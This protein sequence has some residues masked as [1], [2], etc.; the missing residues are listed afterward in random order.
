[1]H[2]I[3]NEM[4]K[5]GGFSVGQTTEFLNYPDDMCLSAVQNGFAVVC[6]ACPSYWYGNL[7]YLKTPPKLDVKP[8]ELFD[9]WDTHV[10]PLA[11]LAKKKVI[12]WEVPTL[13]DYEYLEDEEEFE[14]ELMLKYCPTQDQQSVPEVDVVTLQTSQWDTFFDLHLQTNG[15]IADDFTK[16]QHKY[17]KQL[18]EGGYGQQFVIWD[19]DEIV[20]AAGI[21]WNGTTYRYQ[22]VATKKN[23]RRRGYASAIIAHI[24]DFALKRGAKDLFI[25]AEFDTPQAGIYQRAG[26]KIDSYMLSIIADRT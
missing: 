26:F 21:V 20:A 19:G 4:H 7:F 1:M 3:Y 16:W 25:A 9:L 11:P 8:N 5:T 15:Q 17:F 6:P 14:V 23:H 2:K 24:R 18:Q 22:M 12:I 13:A 10:A